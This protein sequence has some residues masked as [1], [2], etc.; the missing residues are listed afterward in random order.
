[1]AAVPHAPYIQLGSIG[2]HTLGPVRVLVCVA[3]PIGW[4]DKNSDSRKFLLL[5]LGMIPLLVAITP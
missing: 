5:G 1:M 4:N 3:A 2:L